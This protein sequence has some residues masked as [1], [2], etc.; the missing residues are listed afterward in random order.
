MIIAK[1]LR[2]NWGRDI[3]DGR[4]QKVIHSALLRYEALPF[5]EKNRKVLVLFKKDTYVV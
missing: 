5:N 4:R 1:R 2:G 3:V